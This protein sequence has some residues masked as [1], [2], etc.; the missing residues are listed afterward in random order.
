MG[1]I[2]KL[3]VFL[4]S[5]VSIPSGLPSVAEL[6]QLVLSANYYQDEHGNFVE[7]FVNGG[8]QGVAELAA[9]LQ[10]LLQCMHEYDM[11]GSSD[12][13][14]RGTPTYEDLFALCEEIMLWHLGL[15]DNSIPTSF[16][17]AMARSARPLL[18]GRT[19]MA[20]MQELGSLAVDARRFIESAVAGALR[21]PSV[22]GLDL[23]LEFAVSPA[24]EQLNIV[25]LNHDTLAEQYLRQEGVDVVDGFG[26]G[27][28]DVRWYDDRVYD[29]NPGKVRIFKLH[30]SVNWRAISGKSRPAMLIGANAENV[31][32]AERR[33]L[34]LMLRTPTFLTGVNKAIAYQR[35]IY[36]DAHFR[37]HE[38]LRHCTHVVMSGYGWGDTAINWRFDTW[39][40]QDARNT[41]I[42]LH[43]NPE[44]ISERSAIVGSAYDYWIRKQHLVP[45]RKWLCETTLSDVEG[46]LPLAAT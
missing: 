8:A 46:L 16:V 11:R 20:R 12:S 4:G 35:G 38:L 44:E 19:Q 29:R 30:G 14:F 42:L 24:I 40:D 28:G 43:R 5:G 41:I 36:A 33:P 3:I 15:A 22:V 1:W 23:L 21:S 6:T 17:D 31:M 25:T 10:A 18:K 37:F 27:D 26:A 9:R 7:G 45:I 39:L 32:D 34:R 13:V 2:M